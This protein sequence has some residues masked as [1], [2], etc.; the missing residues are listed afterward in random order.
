MHH[1]GFPRFLIHS[2]PHLVKDGYISL[3]NVTH[4]TPLTLVWLEL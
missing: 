4:C 1:L 3:N 2:D